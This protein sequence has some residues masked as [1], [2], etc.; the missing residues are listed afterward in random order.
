LL[1]QCLF[2]QLQDFGLTGDANPLLGNQFLNALQVSG[3][4]AETHRQFVELH[5]LIGEPSDI[6]MAH[7]SCVRYVGDDVARSFLVRRKRKAKEV[8]RD[9]IISY[10]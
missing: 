10:R 9:R 4:P 2:Q 1:R 3:N 7:K 5:P 6:P 8:R